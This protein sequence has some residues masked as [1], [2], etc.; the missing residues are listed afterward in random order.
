MIGNYLCLGDHSKPTSHRSLSRTQQTNGNDDR[1]SSTNHNNTSL[2]PLNSLSTSTTNPTDASLTNT[3]DISS[4]SSNSPLLRLFQF[5]MS[6]LNRIVQY[7]STMSQQLKSYPFKTTLFLFIFI[8]VL[9]FHSFYLIQLAYRIEDRLHALYQR[10]PSSSMKNP[11]S[12]SSL[13]NS[14]PS[15]KEF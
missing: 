3:S 11:L 7:L 9:V 10:W 14:L 2:S 5:V 15:S 12:S 6:F 8:L 4:Y 1:V 13:K